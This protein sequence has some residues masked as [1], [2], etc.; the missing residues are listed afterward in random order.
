L[1]EARTFASGVRL[2]IQRPG[3][4]SDYATTLD[5]QIVNDG[6]RLFQTRFNCDLETVRRR[7]P[8]LRDQRPQRFPGAFGRVE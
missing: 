3:S 5:R 1:L 7:A 6:I 8:Y 2:T 4:D